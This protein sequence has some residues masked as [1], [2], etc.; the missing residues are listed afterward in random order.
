MDEVMV[1]WR[2]GLTEESRSRF[3]LKRK[4]NLKPLTNLATNTMEKVEKETSAKVE[5]WCRACDLGWDESHKMTD[6]ASTEVKMLEKPLAK[7]Q[8][9]EKTA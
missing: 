1:R 3:F 7:Q 9:N 2:L 4:S 8:Q 5:L 6:R